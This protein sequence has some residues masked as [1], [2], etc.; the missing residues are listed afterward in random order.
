MPALSRW[1]HVWPHL[2]LCPHLSP[3]PVTVPSLLGSRVRCDNFHHYRCPQ[4]H[5]P[6]LV[7]GCS[8]SSQTPPPSQACPP[9]HPAPTAC[10]GTLSPCPSPRPEPVPQPGPSS[11]AAPLRGLCRPGR[12]FAGPADPWRRLPRI[13]W[14]AVTPSPHPVFSIRYYAQLKW[15][16][17]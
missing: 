2:A 13:L 14:T 3:S 12:G 15:L 10:L 8:G 17:W 9:P 7:P 1:P 6:D 16:S 4:G 5:H 11:T